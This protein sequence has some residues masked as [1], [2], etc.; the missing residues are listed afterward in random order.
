MPSLAKVPPRGLR[1]PERLDGKISYTVRVMERLP[2]PKALAQRRFAT[3]DTCVGMIQIAER[4]ATDAPQTVRTLLDAVTLPGAEG[5]RICEL[6]FGSGWLLEEMAGAFPDRR[7]FGLDMSPGMVSHVRELIGDRVSVL[8]GD[9]ESLPLREGVFDVMVT[10]WTLYFMRDIGRALEETRRC[11]RRGGRLV[12]V[13]N[14]PDHMLEYDHLAAK[15]LRLALGR[16]PDTEVTGRFDLDTGGPHMRRH[17][18]DVEVREW[19]GWM[20]LPEIEPLLGLWDAWRPDSLNE[21]EE[22]LA[23][24]EFERLARDWLRRDGQIRISRHQGAFV[25]T[26][27]G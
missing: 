27:G 9:M 13:T 17:F 2:D 3:P 23:R 1:T 5:K 21:R 11:L 22:E 19:R 25:G 14:A 15:A 12:A 16:E 26:K 10:C 8:T 6:G 24:A 18:R 20:V 7:L 4:Y